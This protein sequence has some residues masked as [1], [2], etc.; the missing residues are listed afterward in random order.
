M[1]ALTL[2]IALITLAAPALA[3][4]TW[5]PSKYGAE[6]T[7][8]A[9]NNLSPEG[10]VAAAKLVKIGKVYALGIVTGRDTPAW[11]GR[12]YSV[13][14]MPFDDGGGSP[15]GANRVTGHDDLLMTFV[16]IGTQLDGLG[17]VGIDRR[18]YNG[19]HAR[20]IYRPGGVIKFGAETILPTATRGVLLDMVK[21]Y[22]VAQLKPGTAFNRAEIDAAAKAAGVKIAKGD[23]VLFH[24]GWL[25]IAK[26]DPKQFIAGE[27]GLGEEGAN[28]LAS[29][30]VAMIGAD[31]SALEAI[32]SENPERPFIVHQ[33]LLAKHGVH[34]PASRPRMGWNRSSTASMPST[35]PVP[36][37]RLASGTKAGCCSPTATMMAVSPAAILSQR[38]EAMQ[39]RY[40]GTL[41]FIAGDKNST[42]VFPFPIELAQ[43][44]KS[45]V[46][47]Q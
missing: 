14:V 22:K 34:I 12:S 1:R 45:A 46:Q 24:T 9:M 18:H 25:A 44:L 7:K 47:K 13:A 43:L 15:L 3:D 10:A 40:L 26:T 8:G 19:V 6:D 42:V 28:Y 21:H 4:E 23:V 17:H 2:T 16:G 41:N 32:P 20:D 36:P 39:L 29:L 31:T 37:T 35:R 38:P 27:P 11:P 30:G 33:T 5:Y